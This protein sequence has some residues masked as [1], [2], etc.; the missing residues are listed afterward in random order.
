MALSAVLIESNTNLNKFEYSNFFY[1]LTT[2]IGICIGILVHST[3]N[4]N[5]ITSLLVQGIL[6]ALS[7]MRFCI[8]IHKRWNFNVRWTDK[9]CCS[10]FQIFRFYKEYHLSSNASSGI[11]MARSCAHVRIRKICLK[12]MKIY[13]FTRAKLKIIYCNTINVEAYK[14]SQ[15]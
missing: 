8:S 10:S 13:K 1:C 2:P 15:R 12:I 3:Y 4:D 6:D 7:G 9:Y 5:D 11:A 14:A